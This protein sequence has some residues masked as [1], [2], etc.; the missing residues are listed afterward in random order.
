MKKKKR[1]EEMFVIL[2]TKALKV[3]SILKYMSSEV[4]RCYCSSGRRRHR[5]AST[6]VAERSRCAPRCSVVGIGVGAASSAPLADG[7]GTSLQLLL[8]RRRRRRLWSG[9]VYFLVV[10]SVV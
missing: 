6:R 9:C 8:L 1:T 4:K 5:E 3:F 2:C 10:T 7:N